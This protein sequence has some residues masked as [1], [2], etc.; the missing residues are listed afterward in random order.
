MRED[1]NKIEELL[2]RC[3]PSE[4]IVYN[5]IRSFVL[6]NSKRIRSK[7]ALL[8]L[9]ANNREITDDIYKILMSGELVH[10]ASLLHDD[11][12]DDNDVR[13][14]ETTI[15][16]KYSSKM[17]IIAGDYLLSIAVKNLLSIDNSEILNK[18]LIC[19]Q[20]MSKAE[21]K[22]FENRGKKHQLEEYL[23]ICRGKTAAL[24]SAIL[25]SSASI[26]NLP[27]ENAKKLG[28]VFG[29]L[30]QIKNDISPSSREN[31]KKNGVFTV[32]DILSVEKTNNLIDNY[33]E[34]ILSI[35]SK[36]PNEEYK[37]GIEDI[38]NSL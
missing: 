21:I 9:K 33:K 31:D 22:Q 4:N 1:I 25:E 3:L 5:D 30:F 15:G 10:N 11:I 27:Q 18:F 29:I 34:E 24:F 17:S 26:C 2:E 12:I 6:S 19:T 37:Q 23:E 35:I 36:Y 16:K 8:Y 7:L 13:R 32:C 20:K 14:G 28:E 38:I